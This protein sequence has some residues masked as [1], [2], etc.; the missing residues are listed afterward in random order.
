MNEENIKAPIAIFC[1]RRPD[2]LLNTL[3]HLIECNDFDSSPIFF[4]C[5]GPKE[6]D[7]YELVDKTIQ[8]ARKLLP[9]RTEFHISKKNRGLSSS[10][11]NGVSY[12]LERYPNII[13][14]EDD[15]IVDKLFLEYMNKALSFY[16]SNK[17]IFQ[18]SGYN[19][20]E[21]K[22]K[23]SN[24]IFSAPY[25]TSWGWGTWADR[26]NSFNID[27]PGWERLLDN[28]IDRKK[29]DADGAY[30]YSGMLYRQRHGLVDSWAIAWYYAV[31]LKKG[32]T[33]FPP[34]SFVVNNG[35]DGSGSNGSSLIS[36]FGKYTDLDVTVLPE[37]LSAE[38]SLDLKKIKL[39]EK[40][41]YNASGGHVR[42][43]FSF[44]K[45][46]LKKGL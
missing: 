13:V 46:L 36:S 29:F 17:S 31:F 18:I 35:F 33:I 9:S 10:I 42:A 45:N 4:F 19:F 2:H 3:N 32:Y 15:L 16:Q 5:D 24:E 22:D 26:W 30:D 7:D 34:K 6:L 40:A 37:L 1:Y 28:K 25:I 8:V 21:L 11:A 43:A 41:L 39:Y 38:R 12:V 44:I 20:D 23:I 14:V 27:C